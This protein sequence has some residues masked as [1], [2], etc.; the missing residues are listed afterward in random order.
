MKACRRA[1]VV[2]S[3][4][5]ECRLTELLQ[6]LHARSGSCSLLRRNL[7]G[8]ICRPVESMKYYLDKLLILLPH[9][10]C[11]LASSAALRGHTYIPQAEAPLS[12]GRDRIYRRLLYCRCR[13][14]GICKEHLQA[15]F[16]WP[17]SAG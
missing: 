12:E 13:A 8:K 11:I 15:Y 14:S 10:K 9:L 6:D 7:S 3:F 4:C 17:Q 2:L 16:K 1:I 5:E